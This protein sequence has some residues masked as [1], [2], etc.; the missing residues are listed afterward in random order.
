[1]QAYT[2]S[3]A[4][5]HWLNNQWPSPWPIKV[6]QVRSKSILKVFDICGIVH[7]EFISSGQ[8]VHCELKKLDAP[9]WQCVL[10]LRSSHIRVSDQKQQDLIYASTLLTRFGNCGLHP[11]SKNEDPAHRSPLQHHCGDPG[12]ITEGAWDVWKEDFLDIFRKW[13][14]WW[15]RCNTVQRV[16]FGGDD[17]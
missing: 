6:R 14:E 1:M 11:L 8:T 12:Q 9:W 7:R 5:H 13:Q 15:K 16:H 17:V 10:F 4:E 2:M 3:R